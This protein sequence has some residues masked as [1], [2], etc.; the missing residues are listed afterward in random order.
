MEEPTTEQMIERL[1]RAKR[2]VGEL[3]AAI[4]GI[5][6]L[7]AD[8]LWPDSMLELTE[9]QITYHLGVYEERQRWEDGNK[10]KTEEPVAS[11]PAKAGDG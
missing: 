2:A 6:H 1:I 8:G 9:N 11:G 5:Y 10:P 7:H 3:R 4:N